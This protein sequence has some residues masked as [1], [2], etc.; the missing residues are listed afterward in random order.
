LVDPFK[1][2]RAAVAEGH[3]HKDFTDG[4]IWIDDY[5]GQSYTFEGQQGGYRNCDVFRV[6]IK[7]CDKLRALIKTNPTGHSAQLDEVEK[8]YA[9]AKKG[10]KEV[11]IASATKVAASDWPDKADQYIQS[12]TEELGNVPELAEIQVKIKQAKEKIAAKRAA[13]DAASLAESKKRDEENRKWHA[14]MRSAWI[15]P[16]PGGKVYCENEVWTYNAD[17]SASSSDGTT[18]TFNGVNL[19]GSMYGSGYWNGKTFTWSQ[20]NRDLYSFTLEN[21]NF[22]CHTNNLDLAWKWD[23]TILTPL[24]SNSGV[25]GSRNVRFDGKVPVPMLL[26]IAMR[27]WTLHR[28]EEISG[29]F[30]CKSALWNEGVNAKICDKCSANHKPQ[31]AVCQDKL[32]FPR[33]PALMCKYCA[34][35][36][37][38]CVKCGG[39]FPYNAAFLCDA[40]QY[41]FNGNC[42]R[43]TRH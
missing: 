24:S 9:E 31:C 34:N 1:N 3:K 15:T 42:V 10:H 37:P 7:E 41:A 19:S 33:N 26:A 39:S 23:G 6:A 8:L 38:A 4:T 18:Y 27:K 14:E 40:C 30:L 43:T 21:G 17:G 11:C 28:A 29:S 5:N 13:D 32:P 20:S 22:S 36:S 35:L 2:I 25:W 12:A 16:Y